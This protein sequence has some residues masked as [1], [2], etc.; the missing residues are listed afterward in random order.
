MNRLRI[1]SF[2]ALCALPLFFNL[3][4]PVLGPVSDG[5]YAAVA[6]AMARAEDAAH[7]LVPHFEGQPHLTKPPLTYW[8]EAL[9]IRTL[10]RNELAVRLPSAIGGLIVLLGTFSLAHYLGGLRLAL[11]AAG[12]LAVMPLHIVVGRLTLTDGLLAPCWLGTLAGAYLCVDQPTRRLWPVLLWAS[13]AVGLMVKGPL[14]FL[15]LGIVVLWLGAGRKLGEL[16]HL[17][18]ALGLSMSLIPLLL[19]ALAVWQFAPQAIEVWKTEVLGRAT[20]GGEHPQGPWFFPIV[21]LVGCFPAT[22]MLNLPWNN[23]PAPR[24]IQ[25]LKKADPQTL[26][27]WAILVPL[28]LFSIPSGKLATYILPLAPAMAI[29]GAQVLA[30]WLD[31]TY[32]QPEPGIR[33]PDVRHTFMVVVTLCTASGLIALALIDSLPMLWF[34]PFAIVPLVAIWLQK[35]WLRRPQQ[36]SLAL[37]TCWLTLIAAIAYGQVMVPR[38]ID[39]SSP[40]NQVRAAMAQTPGEPVVITYG[41]RDYALS[42]YLDQDVPRTDET[43]ELATALAQFGPSLI[44]AVETSD[45]L[46]LKDRDPALRDR[47][48]IIAEQ[49]MGKRLV[50]IPKPE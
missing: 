49:G 48:T 13:V 50:V 11:L 24:A 19:W 21:L 31:G 8:L 14:I 42:Y 36:R 23:Y 25:A 4:G 46:E 5:R 30:R 27:V 20:G 41:Y 12:L 47:F 28:I 34:M 18:A 45:W 9:C 15:P 37:G 32:D 44:V 39:I 22:C 33:P 29:L 2:L 10:G 17:H 3:G 7:W 40:W 26:W 1:A 38:V 35:I 43:D 6:A 16:K